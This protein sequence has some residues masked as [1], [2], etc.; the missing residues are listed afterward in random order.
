MKIYIA[1][2]ING[3]PGY[4]EKFSAAAAKFKSTDSVLSPAVLPGCMCNADYMHICFAM[5]DVADK[6][7]FLPD[8]K[9]SEGAMLEHQHC[10]YT[11]KAI[12]YL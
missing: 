9:D 8:W 3:D 11:G 7:A 12:I 4:R 6:V 1:G 10:R 2:K 5:I